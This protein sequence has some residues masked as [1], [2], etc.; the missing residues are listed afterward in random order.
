MT[1]VMPTCCPLCAEALRKAQAELKRRRPDF[2]PFVFFDATRPMSV[3]QTMWNAVKDT[4]K[5]FLC[6]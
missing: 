2:E 4:P 5:Y 6:V 3:Q 1:C